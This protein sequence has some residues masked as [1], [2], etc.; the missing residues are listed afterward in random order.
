LNGTWGN[1]RANRGVAADRASGSVQPSSLTLEIQFLQILNGSDDCIK[2]LD[3][4]GRI[5][6]MNQGGQRLLG[7]EDITP[8]LN[9]S[10]VEFWPAAD[11]QAARDAI[12]RAGA[13]EVCSLQGYY[14]TLKGEPKWW[15]N[16]ISPI[17][18]TDGNVEHLLCI[19][20]DI[21]DRQRAE[22]NLRESEARL[23]ADLSR[24]QRLYHLYATLAT[25]TDLRTALNEILAVAC[26]F[27]HT[28][29]GC[30]QLI[31]D[32][33]TQLKML[34]WRGYTDDSPFISHFRHEGFKQGCDQVRVVR[35]RL[36]VEET[37]A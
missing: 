9:T 10:W 31:N 29:R 24:M 30:V 6:F 32:D 19:S 13:G 27:T 36:I 25:E 23:A 3:L 28:E 15:D 12:L 14:P 33:S 37:I 16:K 11:R 4:E 17:R 1:T 8:F 5:L 20:R 7:I 34:T 21:T 18:G 22:A 2:V 26:E 35:Q